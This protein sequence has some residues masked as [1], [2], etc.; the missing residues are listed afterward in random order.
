MTPPT[1][2][3][4]AT[5]YLAERTAR[6][7]LLP[8]SVTTIRYVLWSFTDSVGPQLPA[9]SLNRRHVERW[10]EKHRNTWGRST[11]RNR[12]S[13]VRTFCHWMIENRYITR[14]PTFKGP[15]E[16]KRRPRALPDADVGW[17]VDS[18]VDARAEVM[19]LLMAQEGLRCCEVA[20]LEVG[21]IDFVNAEMIVRGK[22]DKE[23]GLPISD[24]TL[25][26]MRR[27]LAGA[28]I[29]S[30]PLLRSRANPQRG[31]TPGHVSKIVRQFMADAN[32]DGTPH[33]LRH[34]AA[35]G[36]LRA[37]AH[38][39]DVQRALGH[40]NL[41][42][43]ELYLPDEVRGL[44]KA[45]G[46]RQY[47]HR[48]GRTAGQTLG[49]RLGDPSPQQAGP[50]GQGAGVDGGGEPVHLEDRRPIFDKLDP[51]DP[52]RRRGDIMP[53]VA[54]EEDGSDITSIGA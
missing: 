46:G 31:L 23:R 40:A 3:A 2:G 42:T 27:Y 39:R 26:A 12:L 10:L 30:G 6:R 50:A 22:G 28:R 41:S 38:P 44:R 19:V 36:M 33:Q 51:P 15:R 14:D 11:I 35:T 13:I 1:M 49:N 17:L 16:P 37:G 18:T 9:K 7:E 53:T 45:M 54:D 52:Q 24:Q 21:D 48:I 4:L 34:S 47:G 20:S 32:I 25:D 29:K 43:T 8:T 5:K